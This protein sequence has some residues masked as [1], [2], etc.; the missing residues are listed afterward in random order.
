MK[1]VAVIK[2]EKV[3]KAD[4]TEIEKEEDVSYVRKIKEMRKQQMIM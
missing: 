2:I 4:K 3:V 1:S